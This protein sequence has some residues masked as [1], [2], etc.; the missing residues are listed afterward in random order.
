M[1][2]ENT[3]TIRMPIA[4]ATREPDGAPASRFGA[5]WPRAMMRGLYQ[6]PM[7]HRMTMATKAIDENQAMLDCPN[8]TT[9]NAASTGPI[10]EP[11]LPPT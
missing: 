9:I 7:R 3:S 1:Y 4:I 6:P 10:A 8:G 2:F 11:R 5:T